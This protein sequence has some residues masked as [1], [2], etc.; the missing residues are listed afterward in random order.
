MPIRLFSVAFPLTL[1]SLAACLADPERTKET[2]DSL[3]TID[4]IFQGDEFSS[5]DFGGQ[6]QSSGSSYTTLKEGDIFIHDADSTETRLLVPKSLLTDENGQ[7]LKI[8]SYKLSDDLSH[9]LV[10]TNSVRVWRTKSRGDYWVFDRGS[11]QCWQVGKWAPPSTLMFAKFSPDMTNIAYVQGNDIYIEDLRS[12]KCRKVTS[13]HNR[14]VIN[15]TFDWV[16]EEEFQ[17]RDGFRWSPDSNAIAYWQLDT[18]DVP[19]FTMI[20]N[21]DS[22]YPK[23]IQF[24][25]PKPGQVNSACRVGVVDVASGQTQ[26][27]D[28][29][30]DQPDNYIPRIAWREDGKLLI[31]RLNRQQNKND[32]YL[33]DQSGNIQHTFSETDDA[34]VDVHDETLWLNSGREHTWISERDGW[35]HAYVVSSGGVIRLITP[36]EFDVIRLLAVDESLGLAYFL[37]SPNNATEQYLYS[38]KLDGT[39]VTRITASDHAGTHRYRISADAKFA[40][41]TYSTAGAAPVTKLIQLPSHEVVRNL[42]NNEQ[43]AE[44]LEKL[45]RQPVEFFRVNVGDGISMDAW[46][47]KPPNFDPS[48]KYPLLV[49]VYGEPAGS[50]VKNRWGGSR[51]LWHTLMAQKGYVIMSFDNRGT[52]VPRGRGWRK[53]VYRKVGVIA[54]ADQAR[55]VQTVLKERS[56]LD[57]SRVGIWGWSGGGSMSLNAIFKFPDIYKTAVSIAPVP[58]QRYY[59]TIY[60][61]RYMGLPNDNVEGYTQGSPINFA[62]NLKGNLLLVHGTG[63]DNCHYQTMEILINELVSHDKH[64][65][66]MA[67]PNRTHA[68]REGQ[69]TTVHLRRLMTHYLENNL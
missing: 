63:D 40:V 27:V 41:H 57:E 54:A 68:I 20:N 37:A 53:S 47:I 60:Q 15:G 22:L 52:N 31:Q 16:Y 65:T 32:L 48:K 4:R 24:A 44:K 64:F 45:W 34:W 50:T 11:R 7:A 66:M 8:E 19:R 28:F 23:L 49:Y 61:E 69:N 39:G 9:V 67:Y 10:Y 43:L 42:E 29:P 13:K 38:A 12:N 2:D 6:W 21:T 1:L 35:R 30:G 5:K 14:S 3:L 18:T 33:A 25:H 62:K 17:I 59:D 58:N 36:G 55:A 56:Y 51:Y 26:W 46:C